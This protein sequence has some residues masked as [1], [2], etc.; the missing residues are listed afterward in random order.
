MNGGA[1][2]VVEKYLFE[3]PTDLSAWLQAQ[4]VEASTC[5]LFEDHGLDGFTFTLLTESD[6]REMG[7]SRMGVRKRL[8]FLISLWRKQHSSLAVCDLPYLPSTTSFASGSSSDSSLSPHTA[9]GRRRRKPST[10]PAH[11][12][13]ESDPK[14]WKV[15]L[16]AVYAF[17][18]LGL[19]SFVMVLAHERLPEISKYPPLPDILLDNLPYIPWAFEAAELVAL[20]LC[21][22]WIGV[23][24]FH[25]HRHILFRRYCSLLGT[26][27][28]LRSVTMIITSLSVPGRHLST[29]CQPFLMNSYKERF[30]R[31]AEIW[32]RM[33]EF[34][35]TFCLF[36]TETCSI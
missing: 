29:E 28:L 5:Q 1:S 32:F 7:I 11:A 25:K 6:L 4:Y 27:F 14:V 30:Q 33:G 26:V 18:V 31:A 23:L 35:S 9:S 12:F 36:E 34:A 17:L 2:N 20:C 16:S 10:S 21:I 13:C 19:T 8:L 3:S 15:I 22:I 24:I